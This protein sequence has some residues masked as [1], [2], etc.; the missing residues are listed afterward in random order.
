[1]SKHVQRT[2][3]AGVAYF[4]YFA[5]KTDILG[6]AYD[7]PKMDMAADRT[8]DGITHLNLGEVMKGGGEI[9]H[10]ILN[11]PFSDPDRQ[12]TVEKRMRTHT[13]QIWSNQDEIYAKDREDEARQQM[14]AALSLGKP[15]SM[16]DLYRKPFTE[17]VGKKPG[18]VAADAPAANEPYYAQ[19]I[20]PLPKRTPEDYKKQ[21]DTQQQLQPKMQANGS[22]HD[23]V[24]RDF[25]NNTSVQG[26]TIN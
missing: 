11:Q 8:V 21:D 26:Q 17:R 24:V 13:N 4:P 1:M 7:N 20:S 2:V 6:F 16:G 25:G 22:W 19:N 9:V 3:D 12:K 5:L 23:R 18:I 14:E 10:T 15:I